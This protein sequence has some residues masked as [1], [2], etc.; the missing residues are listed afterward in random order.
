M[1]LLTTGASPIAEEVFDFLRICFGA[2]VL[3][4]YG[5]TETSCVVCVTKPGDATSGAY[6]YGMQFLLS[7]FCVWLLLWGWQ[8]DAG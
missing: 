7:I 2:T 8:R 1:R 5:L 4:G 3:E 6:I